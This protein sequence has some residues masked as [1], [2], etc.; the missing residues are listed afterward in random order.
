MYVRVRIHRVVGN[1]P[2]LAAN[3]S[4]LQILFKNH[5]PMVAKRLTRRLALDA[6]DGREP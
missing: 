3:G 1:F 5:R 4:E 6:T 2:T